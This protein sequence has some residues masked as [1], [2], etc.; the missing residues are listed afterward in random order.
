[1]KQEGLVV[2]L[3]LISCGNKD[4]EATID[5]ITSATEPTIDKYEDTTFDS[6]SE[7]IAKAVSSLTDEIGQF[8]FNGMEHTEDVG[9]QLSFTLK[10]TEREL[11]ILYYESI[12]DCYI[13][14]AQTGYIYYAPNTFASV[15]HDIYDFETDEL[16]QPTSSKTP[17]DLL[18]DY[19]N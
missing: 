11:N 6:A 2:S 9:N 5:P 13:A 7:T 10:L 16:I 14:D 19:M 4:T 1:M 8:T 17:A 12:Y 18:N 3:L 15:M